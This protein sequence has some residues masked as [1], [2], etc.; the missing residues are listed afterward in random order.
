MAAP[1]APASHD[2]AHALPGPDPSASSARRLRRLLVRSTLVV[3]VVATAVFGGAAIA[4]WNVTGT[5]AG[6]AEAAEA[7]ELTPS[8]EIVGALYPGV[9]ADADLTV[10]NGNLF[11]V[12]LTDIVFGAITVTPLEG[13]TCDA[14]DAA[15]TFAADLIAPADELVVP[16]GDGDTAGSATFPLQDAVT[17]GAGALDDCQGASF[18]VAIT[19]EAE[20]TTLPPTE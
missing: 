12:L 13:K 18:S 2:G 6:S 20:S 7:A 1:A 3:G 15:V 8:L 19:L 4:A 14:E 5:G 17:M 16:A 9:T 10:L 11:N